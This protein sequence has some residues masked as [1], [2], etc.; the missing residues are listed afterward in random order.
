M[1]ALGHKINIGY[2]NG[3]YLN[4]LKFTVDGKK[5]SLAN[6]KKWTEEAIESRNKAMVNR[7]CKLYAFDS[8]KNKVDELF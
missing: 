1:T 2:K 5:Y 6:I 8:E 3:L 4:N 7:I